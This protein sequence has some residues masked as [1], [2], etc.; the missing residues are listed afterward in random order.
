MHSTDEYLM[1][2]PLLPDSLMQRNLRKMSSNRVF[3]LRG[4]RRF[5]FSQK[6]RV[7]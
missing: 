2:T 6:A 3:P 7:T 4:N 1:A 5:L